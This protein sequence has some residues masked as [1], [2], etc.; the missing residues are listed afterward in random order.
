MVSET[1]CKNRPPQPPTAHQRHQ[2]RLHPACANADY[3]HHT[4]FQAV[5]CP[6]ASKGL[7]IMHPLYL[8]G[9][10]LQRLCSRN[11]NP[12]TSD[13]TIPTLL[14]F[15]TISGPAKCLPTALYRPLDSSQSPQRIHRQYGVSQFTI[16][17]AGRAYYRWKIK[18]CSKRHWKGLPGLS[19]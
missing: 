6:S 12:G 11:S 16:R 4:R 7:R 13:Q 17:D 18:D 19:L 8:K 5:S 9:M 10:L 2:K 15:L 3:T 1:S 14:I